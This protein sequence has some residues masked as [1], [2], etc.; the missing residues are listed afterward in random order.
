MGGGRN[1]MGLLEDECRSHER[2]HPDR[3]PEAVAV[4]PC[5]PNIS[6]ECACVTF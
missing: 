4:A 3:N 2:C 5:S 1:D 6:P